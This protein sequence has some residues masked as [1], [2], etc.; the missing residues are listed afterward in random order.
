M[1]AALMQSLILPRRKYSSRAMKMGV[2]TFFLVVLVI[3]R[4]NFILLRQWEQG[5]VHGYIR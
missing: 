5:T 2:F 1:T 4:E 3:L